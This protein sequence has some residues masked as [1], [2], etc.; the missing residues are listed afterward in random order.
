MLRSV[1]TF[2]KDHVVS[3]CDRP[4][5]NAA[6]AHV[7]GAQ[8][9]GLPLT[10]RGKINAQGLI[11]DGI[12]CVEPEQRMGAPILAVVV[13]AGDLQR[14]TTTGLQGL[15]KRRRKGGFAGRGRATDAED[16]P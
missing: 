9:L 14:L 11:I 3:S 13:V 6:G 15:R 8:S 5:L 10:C 7:V 4:P 1:G 12:G 2:Q 16:R